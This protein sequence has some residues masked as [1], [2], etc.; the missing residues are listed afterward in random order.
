MVTERSRSAVSFSKIIK[1]V[2]VSACMYLN[3]LFL[4][5]TRE[6]PKIGSKKTLSGDLG[7]YFMLLFTNMYQTNCISIF[8]EK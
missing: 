5:K 1:G 8:E 7:M 2:E 4:K 3:P 6:N